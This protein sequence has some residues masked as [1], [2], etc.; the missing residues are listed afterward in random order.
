MLAVKIHRKL[1]TKLDISLFEISKLIEIST[2]I[3]F[4]I[5]TARTLARI[6]GCCS[7]RRCHFC[8]RLLSCSVIL[9]VPALHRIDV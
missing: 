6:I 7:S 2:C 8:L 1:E 3:N 5:F 4:S 9:A